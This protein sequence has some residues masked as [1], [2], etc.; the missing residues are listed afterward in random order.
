MG[1]KSYICKTMSP[2]L[3]KTMGQNQRWKNPGS[4]S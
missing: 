4:E 1:V 2:L 3:V